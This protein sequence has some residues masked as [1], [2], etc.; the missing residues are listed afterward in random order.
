MNTDLHILMSEDK[1]TAKTVYQ[2]WFSSRLQDD[3]ASQVNG[4]RHVTRVTPEKTI[5]SDQV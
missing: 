4:T 5:N 1:P 2:A 3:N